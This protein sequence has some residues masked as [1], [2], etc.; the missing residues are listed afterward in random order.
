LGLTALFAQLLLKPGIVDSLSQ[1]AGIRKKMSPL[2]IKFGI[3][4]LDRFPNG[5]RRSF[6][7]A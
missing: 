4:F 6:P 7:N 5:A 2:L 1:A 3:G